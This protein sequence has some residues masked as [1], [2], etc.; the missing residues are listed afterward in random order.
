MGDRP[1]ET[2]E[3]IRARR[4]KISRSSRIY[5]KLAKDALKESKVNPKAFTEYLTL[6]IYNEMLL[7]ENPEVY[8][9]AA[10]EMLAYTLARKRSE[11]ESAGKGK[12]KVEQTSGLKLDLPTPKEPKRLPQSV[13]DKI[14][15]IKEANSGK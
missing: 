2:P 9:K 7:D 10:R 15:Q 3:S 5:I 14:H 12:L 4:I 6:D 1:V 11:Q 8:R 13:A